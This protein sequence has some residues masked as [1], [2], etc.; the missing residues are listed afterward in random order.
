MRTRFARVVG[1]PVQGNKC[2]NKISSRGLAGVPRECNDPHFNGMDCS[3]ADAGCFPH[4]VVVARNCSKLGNPGKSS[5]D[6][7]LAGTLYTVHIKSGYGD[8]L[9]RCRFL[10]E[11]H[12]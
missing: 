3:V 5:L 2:C 1:F 8:R 10:M 12:L 11:M 4:L 9:T 6:Q 7:D